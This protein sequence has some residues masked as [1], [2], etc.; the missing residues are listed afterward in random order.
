M[1]LIPRLF[2]NDFGPSE[3]QAMMTAEISLSKS[4]AIT[5]ITLNL[6]FKN[7]VIYTVYSHT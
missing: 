4:T 6:K 5:F 1:I 7:N 2:A 3:N